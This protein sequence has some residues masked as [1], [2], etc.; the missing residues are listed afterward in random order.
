MLNVF[1]CLFEG[2][3]EKKKCISELQK[4]VK[5][6]GGEIV[7]LEY[8]SKYFGNIILKFKKNN[9]M[10]EYVVDRDEIYFNKRMIGNNAYIRE[11][12]K[13]HYQKLIEIINTTQTD[14]G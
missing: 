8:S 2:L 1:L 11:E 6:I 5:N 13:K 12:G 14:E 4:A 3:R 7:Y 10:Y 9:L